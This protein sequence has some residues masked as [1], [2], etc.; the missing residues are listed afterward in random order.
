MPIVE[1]AE[2]IRI[3]RLNTAFF[4]GV[5]TFLSVG[6]EKAD[7]SLGTIGLVRAKELVERFCSGVILPASDRHILLRLQQIL[8]APLQQFKFGGS[9]RVF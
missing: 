9:S 1:V 8:L 4:C 7:C 6:S 2:E 5:R 3:L